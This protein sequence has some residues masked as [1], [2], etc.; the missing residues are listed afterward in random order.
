MNANLISRFPLTYKGFHILPPMNT[1]YSRLV[2]G[3][4]ITVE[5]CNDIPGKL[6]FM[7]SKHHNKAVY[8]KR[9][10]VMLL[11]L[12]N[13]IIQNFHD[14]QWNS[15]HNC[16]KEGSTKVTFEPCPHADL[17]HSHSLI[18]LSNIIL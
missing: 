7:W 13:S 8:Y 9:M 14:T 5:R 16:K 4:Q 1:K 11:S 12:L 3:T 2:F 18:S 6:Y 17:K 15:F 10:F